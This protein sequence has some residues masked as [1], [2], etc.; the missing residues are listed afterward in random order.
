MPSTR[1][2]LRPVLAALLT[3]TMLLAPALL[4]GAASPAS[5]AAPATP[6]APSAPS[7]PTAPPAPSAPSEGADSAVD[8]T[9]T[10]LDPTSLAPGG[11]LTARVRVTNTSEE[12]LDAA[13]L[14]LRTRSSRV[15]DRAQLSQWEG[16][17]GPDT[18]GEPVASSDPTVIAPGDSA[19]LQI[20]VPAEDLG[21]SGESYLWGT[22][23][24]SLTLSTSDGPQDAI[25][26]FVVWR[27]EGASGSITESVLLPMTGTDPGAAAADPSAYAD[28]AASG[29][30][31]SLQALAGREDVDWWLDPQLL[32]PPRLE[33]AEQGDPQTTNG[34]AAAEYAVPEAAQA[35]ASTLQDAVGSRTVL[36]MPYAR[37]DLAGLREAGAAD[38][39]DAADALGRDTWQASGIILRSRAVGIPGDE[40]TAEALD[41]AAATGADTVIVP[42]TSVREDPGSSVTPSSIGTYEATGATGSGRDLRVL[43]P[44][45]E[46]SAEFASLDGGTDPELVTQRMLAETATIASEYSQAPRHLLISPDPEAALDAE[47]AG[48]ALDALDEAPWLTRGTTDALL[49][50][51]EQDAVTTNPSTPGDDLYALGTIDPATVAPSAE[52]EDGTWT[53]TDPADVAA[54][55]DI[56]PALA[57]RLQDLWGELDTLGAVMEDDAALDGPRLEVLSAASEH[58]G[59][60]ADSTARAELAESAVADLTGAISVVPTSGYNLIS[61]SAGVP[62]TV[63]NSLDTPITVRIA[64][65]S[66]RPI[67]RVGE[68]P[69]VTV[70]ARGQIDKT[71]PVEAIA[72]GTVTLSVQLTSDPDAEDAPD[73]GEQAL[74]SISEVPLTVNPA[75][76]N[77]TTLL[78]VIGMGALVVV[79]VARARHT[80][81]SHRA[82]AVH[83]PEDPVVLARTGRSEPTTE[84][85]PPTADDAHPDPTTET[86][87]E[88]AAAAEDPEQKEER[89]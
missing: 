80:G 42:S 88:A 23:R 22:R 13:S 40:V 66:D 67:V 55:T 25:R 81:S 37:T 9:L 59:S 62:I 48:T 63:K 57:R 82:P 1:P 39:A 64:V 84:P 85:L 68:Q 47:A 46:L 74:T 15:T 73:G 14:E 86:G 3:V 76:E 21:F 77:W 58:W 26:T 32:D 41:E 6:A 12:S 79:G 27:P 7:A 30:L 33:V 71:V 43:A 78:L 75:W 20:R 34:D 31:A 17:T 29:H 89:P 87:S 18:A 35:I 70:P 49:S 28:S 16:L 51:A 61:D 72:N 11:T 2:L 24:I 8:L 65:S 4:A 10:S 83:G 36:A 44:D 60:A 54:A 53:R 69:V 56:A 50:A 19:T 45:P 38:L 5:A 52:S